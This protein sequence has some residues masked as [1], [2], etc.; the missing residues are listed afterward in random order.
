MCKVGGL[1]SVVEAKG[2]AEKQAFECMLSKAMVWHFGRVWP[3]GAACPGSPDRE[4]L[5]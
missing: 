4:A 2:T 1:K 5:K 3:Q